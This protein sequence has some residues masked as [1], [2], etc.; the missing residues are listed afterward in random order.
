[1]RGREKLHSCACSTYVCGFIPIFALCG[2]LC[3]L[4]RRG[5]KRHFQLPAPIYSGIDGGEAILKRAKPSSAHSWLGWMDVC[6]FQPLTL[7]I[8]Y[9]SPWQILSSPPVLSD[10]GHVLVMYGAFLSKL[11]AKYCC[12]RSLSALRLA[13]SNTPEQGYKPN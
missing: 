4:W 3:I 5:R 13:L 10:V 2:T 7:L 11:A 12:C 9:S 8:F 6:E 1:M